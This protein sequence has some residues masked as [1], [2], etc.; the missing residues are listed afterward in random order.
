MNTADP[1]SDTA[2]LP[3]KMLY[4]TFVEKQAG[5]RV[6]NGFIS[7]N[8]VATICTWIKEHKIDSYEGFAKMYDGLSKEARQELEDIDAD[9]KKGLFDGY[10]Q[11]LTQFY[12]AAQKDNN[13]I[14]IC[15]E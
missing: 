11:P 3:Y 1:F 15:R 4:G 2:A 9:D 7:T 5:D 6:I 12:F 10:V 8:E 13:S 14:V